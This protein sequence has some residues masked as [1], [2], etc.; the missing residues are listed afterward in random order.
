[1]EEIKITVGYERGRC[2]VCEQMT[3]VRLVMDEKK[4]AKICNKCVEEMKNESG[5]TILRKYG[6]KRD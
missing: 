4:I 2:S 1:M 3:Q 5:D 6:R